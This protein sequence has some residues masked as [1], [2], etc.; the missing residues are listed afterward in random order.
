MQV[1]QLHNS[2]VIVDFHSQQLTFLDQRFYRTPSGGFVPS[3]TTILDAYPKTPDYYAWLKKMGED[4]DTIRDE[5]GRRGSVVHK[6]TELYDAGEEVCLI[7]ESGRINYSTIE[8]AMF[9]RY[10]DFIGRYAPN[11]IH[12]E[13]NLMSD[14]LGF[15][16]TMDRVIMLD[17][18]RVI[19][20]DIKTSNAIYPSYWLQLAAY[21]ELLK[22]AQG[23]DIIDDVAI[24]WL[25][26]KTRTEGRNGAIQGIGWQL[27]I[28]DRAEVAKDWEL[29]KA[30]KT[31]WLAQNE[32][33]KPRNISYQL[34][35]KKNGSR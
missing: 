7:D 23:E 1:I 28:R 24:L 17:D 8:W 20:V 6:L 4:S 9:T 21:R 32:D 19:M 30:T 11:V 5:A 34:K 16:G 31:L 10:V 13:L 33:L 3:V 29:F 15:A 12:S 22:E 26:A 18:G 2:N 25:N 35:F 27:L 14:E